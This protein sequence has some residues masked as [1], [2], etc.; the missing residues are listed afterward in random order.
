MTL[1]GDVLDEIP[2]EYRERFEAI[3]T[4]PL[5]SVDHVLIEIKRYVA[6]VHQIAPMVRSLDPVLAD[7]LAVSC[8]ALLERHG[9]G[10]EGTLA[11]AAATYFVE[12]ED[13]DEI[14]G[15]LGFDDDAQVVNA[16][17]RVL[18]HVDL[19]VSIR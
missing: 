14:T 18:G 1:L 12:E 15:V 10:E 3:A 2:I 5:G 4:G 13:D 19:I 16:V 6:T 9:E 11:L 17:C 8:S 7:R